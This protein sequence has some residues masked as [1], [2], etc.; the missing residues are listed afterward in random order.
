MSTQIPTQPSLDTRIYSR[1]LSTDFDSISHIRPAHYVI[2]TQGAFGRKVQEILALTL[3]Q[4]IFFSKLEFTMP[5]FAQE[6]GI[7]SHFLS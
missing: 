1:L 6:L 5:C 2:D 4:S 7:F 3:F